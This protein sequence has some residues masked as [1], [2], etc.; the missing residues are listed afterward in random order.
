MTIDT[1]TTTIGTND[2][3]YF[4]GEGDCRIQF[5]E[6][7]MDSLIFGQIHSEML[8]DAFVNFCSMTFSS[9][10]TPSC[11]R[12]DL[13]SEVI[14]DIQEELPLFKD[15]FAYAFFKLMLIFVY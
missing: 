1:I 15:N 10:S 14:K 6:D 8:A 5:T 13:S 11:F 7:E 3:G 4:I 2:V 12:Q 9:G